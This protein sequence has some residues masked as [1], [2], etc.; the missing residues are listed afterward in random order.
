[1]SM[2]LRV[3]IV[4]DSDDDELMIV[5][6]LQS[7]GYD[8]TYTRV[9]TAVEM[10]AALDLNIW[11]LVLCDYC[12]PDFD[13]LEALKIMQNKGIDLPFI[14]VSGAINEEIAVSAMKAGASDFVTKS[15]LM[16]LVPAIR[17]ELKE[18]ENRRARLKSELALQKTQEQLRFV[19]ETNF[20]GTWEWNI[21]T[22]EITCSS[23]CEY[24]FDITS[25]TGS[26]LDIFID[27]IHPQD[28]DAML[29]A[30][31]TAQ[32]LHQTY[33]HEYRVIW[34]D[35]SIH[36]IQ[37]IGDFYQP[38]DAKDNLSSKNY[39][40]MLGIVIDVTKQK[41]AEQKIYEQAALLDVATNAILLRHLNGIVT[42]WNKGAERLYG[43]TAE[44][45]I[46]KNA[47]NILYG[48]YL[49]PETALESVIKYGEWQGELNKV[50]KD[51]QDIIV[52][53]H[54]T[55]IRGED[56][57]PKYILTVDT[58]ITA[59]KQL[60]SRFMRTQRLENIGILAGGIAH[61]LN[62]ILTPIL[63]VAQLLPLTLPNLNTRNQDMLHI[64]E[65]SAKRGADL[66]K[67]ILC[68][69]RGNDEKRLIL[70][71]KHLLLDIEQIIQGT[72]PKSIEI[73]K[74]IHDDLWTISADSTQLHQ[75][76]M[77]LAINARDAMPEGGT[78]TITAEN[79]VIDTNYTKMNID[80]H[81]GNYILITFQD[82]GIGIRKDIIDKIFDPFFTTKEVG[83]GTGLGLS[84]VFNIIKN[85][86]GFIEVD[87]SSKGS[88]FKI[89]IPASTQTNTK[90]KEDT[91]IT[92]GNGELI[93]FVDDEIAISEVS[94]TTLETHKYQV[95][96]ANNGIEAIAI[97]VQNKLTIK[98]VIIDLMMPSLDGVTT[99][100][101][102][103]KIMP[104]IKII[105]MSGSNDSEEKTKAIECGVQE[106]VPKPFTANILLNTLHHVLN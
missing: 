2:P 67:Q 94:K 15:R 30:L 63:A 35:G 82:T 27:R 68:F 80:A 8:V 91:S 90:I 104:N 51:E 46:G 59:K 26:N 53:S 71:V 45:V 81:E 89:F 10:D 65:A 4:E 21:T 58:D 34:Q 83:K 98:A 106:F 38:T 23:S 1:M 11:D 97:F 22:N 6:T 96:V 48:D 5:R 54:W 85:H 7:N 25:G 76:F 39:N 55:L 79:Q 99:I 77:N 57:Q 24:L 43:W 56:N 64:L 69:A 50:T 47:Y 62:N 92:N 18:A 52:D 9:E 102:L 40:R 95:L 88:T 37:A 101:A 13:G 70:Q 87:S 72:F 29:E 103:Q 28:R 86:N 93:L 73:N 100:R 12:L 44:E 49:P 36:W 42:Y 75:V 3:L 16:R 41:L 66:V 84:T 78:L 61:D 60:E 32:K 19:L 105:A 20:M 33:Q 17:R 31:K 14:I 74:H